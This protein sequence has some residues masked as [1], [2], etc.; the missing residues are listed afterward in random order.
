[1]DANTVIKVENLSKKYRLGTIGAKTLREELQNKRNRNQGN[2]NKEEGDFYALQDI[3]FSIQRGERVGIIGHNGAG[4]STLLKI[5]TRITAPTD[6]YFEYK[7]KIAGMLEVGTG[8]HPELTGRENIY[9]NGA[10]LGMKKKEIESKI[11]EIIEYS[12]LRDFI[13]TPVKRYSSG[14]YVKLAFAVAAHLESDILVMDEVLAVGDMKFQEKCLNTMGNVSENEKKTILYVSHNMNT[15]RQLCTRCIVLD[16]GQIVFDG[17]VNTAIEIYS[18]MKGQNL[19]DFVDLGSLKRTDNFFGKEVRF[20]EFSIKN[21]QSGVISQSNN[22]EYLMTIDSSIQTENYCFRI[23]I[24][25]NNGLPVAMAG[26]PKRA[27][28]LKVGEN[29][30]H[31]T[32]GSS[33]LAPGKYYLKFALF[34]VNDFGTERLLDMVD[35]AFH[36]EIDSSN[37]LNNTPWL[38]SYWGNVQIPLTVGEFKRK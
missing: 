15:V 1:M 34:E 36:F 38:E 28:K 23:M 3:T 18:G 32:I 8:F 25:K 12:G 10:I 4:K 7:G 35:H 6:G 26:I 13:D 19:D 2:S 17:D 21:S 24:Y 29:S 16:K 30:L 27:L 22:I 11:D 14:M 31:G 33:V 5:L 37:L 20:I 9:L